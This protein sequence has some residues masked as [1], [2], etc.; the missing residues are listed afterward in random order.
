[1]SRRHIRDPFRLE[2][3]R[4]V[5]RKPREKVIAAAL[6]ALGLLVAIGIGALIA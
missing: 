1:M 6:V 4:F 5:I 2:P 3:A